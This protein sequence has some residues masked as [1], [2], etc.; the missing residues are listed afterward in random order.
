MVFAKSKHFRRIPARSLSQRHRPRGIAVV[1]VL[2]LLAITLA[3]SY[4]TLRGQGTTSQLAHNNARA[5]QARVAAQSGLAVAVRKISENSWGG[6]AST[7]TSNVTDHSWYQVRFETGDVRLATTVLTLPTSDP[8]RIE[9]PFQVTIDSVGYASD[10][11]NPAVRSEHKCRCVVR[12]LR[13]KLVA[14]PSFWDPMTD[15]TVFQ[16]SAQD[17]YVQFP[18]RISGSARL[19]G[20]LR[21]CTEYPNSNLARDQ[22]LSDL[23]LRRIA[24]LGDDRPFPS[25]MTLR[26]LLT[27]QDA[28]T[29]AVLTTKLGMVVT[30]TAVPAAAPVSHPGTVN[31]YRL[32]PGGQEYS[33]P[34]LQY[35]YGNPIS[36]ATIG[37]HPKE[38]PL[39]IYRSQGSL[40]LGNNANITGTIIADGSGP[41]IQV[42]GTG[43]V[44]KALDLPSL[45]GTNVVYQLPVMLVNDDLRFNSGSNAKITGMAMVWDEFE[46]KS[47]AVNSEFELKGNLVT[48]TLQLRGRT[49]WT[50]TPTQWSIDRLTFLSQIV[51]GTPFFPDYEQNLRGFTVKPALT[52]EP[53]SSGVKP[54]WH[55]WSQPIYQAD[56]ADPGLCWEIVRWED[57]L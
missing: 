41:D 48:S 4:A 8:R 16:Y 1:M 13:K 20:R 25:T 34:L 52:F 40:T 54:H 19:H 7:L 12:L 44:L 39:G 51:T 2:G 6:I 26:G 50:Q 33:T 22:Y 29:V 57:N 45:Y 24:L 3:I 15:I 42:T 53:N 23:N 27:V 10:P 55:D 11:L 49:S 32:Y 43:V 37:P 9:Y 56:P 17:A 36:N 28:A 5:L 18:V 21:F 35:D 31:N 14:P 46:L 30:D 47:G 38:N